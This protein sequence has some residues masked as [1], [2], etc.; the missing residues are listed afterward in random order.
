MKISLSWLKQYVDITV[1][2][3]ELCDKM[4]MSG[5]EVEEIIDLSATMRNVVVGRIV[6]LEKHPD[7]DKLQICQVDIGTQE[8]VQIVTGATNV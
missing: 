8:P 3:Q 7:A 5:F 6:K 4:V 1:P 2:V